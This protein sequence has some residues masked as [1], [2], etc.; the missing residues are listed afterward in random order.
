MDFDMTHQAVGRDGRRS[1]RR[2][3]TWLIF[4]LVGVMMGVTWAAGI[5]S[6]STTVDAAGASDA[7]RV[8]ATS[9]GAA[10]ASEYAGLVSE[11]TPLTIGFTGNWG[12]ID[13]DTGIFDLDLDGQTGT[14]FVEVIVTNN[15]TGW[16]AL[17]LEFLQVNK[18]CADAGAADWAAP[19]A[20]SVMVI[21]TEDAFA[22]FD[23]L[24]G[25]TDVCIGIQATSKANDRNGTF[26]RRPKDGSPTGPDFVAV[27]NRSA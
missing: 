19:D 3:L 8:F 18:A 13:A 27:L 6:S 26:I 10:P 11:D 12:R 15:P 24:V 17:Q 2:L 14:F 9:S 4:G 7:A 1:R 20:T 25:G 23:S 22:S 5:A 21:E 16:A